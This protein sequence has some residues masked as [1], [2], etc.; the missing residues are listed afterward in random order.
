MSIEEALKNTLVQIQAR[1][2]LLEK[3]L[4]LSMPVKIP[5]NPGCEQ[6]TIVTHGECIL[7]RKSLPVFLIIEFLPHFSDAK[8]FDY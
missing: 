5:G 6:M 1:V 3:L 4:V 7:L 8:M 2:D